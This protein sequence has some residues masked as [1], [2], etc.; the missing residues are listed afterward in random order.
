[1]EPTVLIRRERRAA[2]R[3]PNWTA[4]PLARQVQQLISARGLLRR[5]DRAVIGVSGGADSVALLHVLTLL[6]GPLA[7]TLTIVHIDHQLRATSADDARFVQA[8]GARFNLPVIVEQRNVEA[9]AQRSGW[10]LEDGA[11]RV[12]HQLFIEAADRVSARAILL[13]HTADDQAETV[14]MRLLRGAG[15]TGLGAMTL[16]R[17]CGQEPGPVRPNSLMVVRPLLQSWRADILTHLAKAKL[18][19]RQDESNQDVRFLRNR[20][21]HE[22]LPLLEREY[23]PNIRT[24]LLQLAE[25]CRVDTGALAAGVRRIWKRTV[26]GL[27]SGQWSVSISTLRRQPLALQRQVIREMIRALQGDL[28]RFEFRHW[29]VLEQLMVAKP[30]GTV[31]DLPGGIRCIKGQDR[32]VCERAAKPAADPL[33]D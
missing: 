18:T 8:L 11:R 7:L 4:F 29:L 26:K 30:V 20:I 12:R 33:E 16:T 9:I 13:A 15:P 31:T 24:G 17:P 21:R 1:M 25:Q 19:Y 28:A 5:G 22:L 14:L 32:L 23:N 3:V 2:P 10:S 27:P 6:K